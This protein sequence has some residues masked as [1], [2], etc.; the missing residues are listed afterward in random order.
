MLLDDAKRRSCP[1]KQCSYRDYS[2]LISRQP[3]M[4]RWPESI[5]EAHTH[6]DSSIQSASGTFQDEDV[7]FVVAA[8]AIRVV[9][10]GD[11]EPS[12][13]VKDAKKHVVVLVKDLL[14]SR[15]LLQRKKGKSGTSAALLRVLHSSWNHAVVSVQHSNTVARV[16]PCQSYQPDRKLSFWQLQCLKCQNIGKQPVEPS[17]QVWAYQH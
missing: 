1:S 4:L 13:R 7:A 12:L 10:V 9:H 6:H 14:E 16:G 3:L 15:W 11:V 8:Y 17:T 2:L 5:L